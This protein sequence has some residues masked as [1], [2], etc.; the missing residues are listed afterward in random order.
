MDDVDIRY[1][2]QAREMDREAA[3]MQQALATEAKLEQEVQRMREDVQRARWQQELGRDMH[4]LQREFRMSDDYGAPPYRPSGR[5][6]SWKDV[7]AGGYRE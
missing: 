6:P 7:C 1:A 5:R 2:Q 4:P 3:L